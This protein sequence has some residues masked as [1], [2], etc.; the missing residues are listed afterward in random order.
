[1]EFCNASGC[2]DSIADLATQSISQSAQKR[3]AQKTRPAR[4]L[5]VCDAV[6][7]DPDLFKPSKS[8]ESPILIQ[9]REAGRGS[10]LRKGPDGVI[11]G[12]IQGQQKRSRS[13]DNS[14]V[15]EGSGCTNNH[16]KP[17]DLSDSPLPAQKREAA[18]GSSLGKAA[19][20]IVDGIGAV[21][22]LITIGTAVQGQ[23]REVQRSGSGSSTVTCLAIGCENEQL[24]QLLENPIQAQQKREA[25]KSKGKVIGNVAQGIAGAVSGAA[26]VIGIGGAVQGQN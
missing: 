21:G 4:R 1:M 6:H 16:L 13:G 11:D 25:Q 8:P 5:V 26:G 17:I 15:C 23:K 12:T 20:G 9:K 18:R 2:A 24:K 3:E 7:C 22:D 14:G 10:S 19:S